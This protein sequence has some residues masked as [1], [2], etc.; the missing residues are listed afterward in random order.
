MILKITKKV[1]VKVDLVFIS[2]FCF[3]TVSLQA[4]ENSGAVAAP[5]PSLQAPVHA[6][7]PLR[8]AVIAGN[9]PLVR[10][11]LATGAAEVNEVDAQKRTA[12]HIMLAGSDTPRTQKMVRVLLESKASVEYPDS[13]GIKPIDYV[14]F[15]GFVIQTLFFNL[16]RKE[17]GEIEC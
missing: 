5:L 3:A 16:L 12:L 4:M 1:M 11:L 9:A 6:R 17:G 15:Q 13:Y 10:E 8:S 2:C 7:S 14:A